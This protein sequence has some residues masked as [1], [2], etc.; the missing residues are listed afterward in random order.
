MPHIVVGTAGHIDHGKSTLVQ[1]LTGIDPDRLKE[2]KERGI[3][4]DLGFAHWTEG[5]VHVA[6]VDVPGHERFI[7][8]MLAGVSGIDCVLLVV[9]ADESV[10]P[11]TREHFAICRLLRIPRGLIVL[12]KADLVDEDMLNL[13]RL[14]VAELVAGSMLERA[15]VV[16]VSAKT[17][18]G[19][20]L[21]RTEIARL[22][23]IGE[24]RPAD[25]SA[26]LPIDRVFS[27]RGFGTV[28][29][30]TLVAGRLVLDQD[31]A[32]LPGGPLV[33]VRGL[34]VHGR[35]QSQAVAGH[36]VAVNVSGITVGDVDRGQTLAEPG[37]FDTTTVLDAEIELLPSARALKHGARVRF[38]H[39]TA[40]LMGRVGVLSADARTAPPAIA[41]GSRAYVR[42]RLEGGAVVTHGDRF[43]LRAYSPL[44]TIAGGR[45]LDPQ[46]PRSGLRR[47]DTRRR[48]EALAAGSSDA[49]LRFVEEAGAA[50]FPTASLVSRAGLTPAEASTATTRRELSG[51]VE[52]IGERLFATR[53]RG[54]LRRRLLDRLAEHHR[55]QPLSEG[56]PRE[57][58]RESLEPH[59]AGALVD[60]VLAD[61]IAE[62]LVVGTDRLALRGRGVTLSAE[63]SAARERLERCYLEAGLTPPDTVSVARQVGVDTGLAERMVSLLVR[64]KAL[65][66]LDVLMFHRE[67][68]ARLKQD[69]MALKISGEQ[70][71]VDVASFKER[72]GLTRKY[73]IPLLEFLDRERVTRRQGDAR[74][75]L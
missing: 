47:P 28:V 9:A 41:P 4:I 33:K 11:Q 42:L 56:W 62:G 48:F 34:Q 36:R 75:I 52:T 24:D 35:A 73:A 43:I 10:M 58:A 60:R 26:R 14:E 72:F 59:A 3:T 7:R 12:T 66:R 22:A 21:L 8:N 38:H 32:V 68:L 65:V 71:T 39:G 37:S 55:A 63:E 2:E 17:G 25:G 1:A 61:A 6:F 57:E 67:A 50:G 44:E 70:A 5:D 46:A 64:Q 74:I 15:P 40:E 18:A 20:P 31:L 13:V 49:V 27:M 16:A 54:D 19:L 29:T 23:R 45:V 51:H 69:V 30:G 53:W